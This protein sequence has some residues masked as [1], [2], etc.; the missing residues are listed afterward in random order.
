M[1]EKK[2]VWEVA[3]L[4]GDYVCPSCEAMRVELAKRQKAIGRL[5]AKVR[6]LSDE[7]ERVKRAVGLRHKGN[8]AIIRNEWIETEGRWGNYPNPDYDYD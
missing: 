8:L 1:S 5:Q 3:P 4:E 7:L 2:A 6:E